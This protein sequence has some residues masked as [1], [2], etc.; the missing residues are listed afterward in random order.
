MSRNVHIWLPT[1]L[2]RAWERAR[3]GQRTAVQHV[4]FCVADHFE[5]YWA[6]ADAATAERRVKRWCRRYPELAAA[7]VDSDGRRPQHT[8]FYPAEEY[9]AGILDRL[10][11]LRDDGFG[12]VEVHLHHDNDTAEKL[13]NTL[14]SFKQTL[15]ERHGLLRR[16]P[17]TGEIVYA[18]IHGNWALDNSRPD[19]RW[20]GVDNELEVL[21]NTGCRVDMT[22]PSAPSPTQTRKINSLYFARGRACE[23]KAHDGGRDVAVGGWGDPGELLLIQ[24][25]LMLN[26]QRRK[27]G[28]L[29]RIE[30]GELSADN[31]PTSDRVRIWG[32]SGVSVR[33]AEQHLF[34]KVHTHGLQEATTEMLLG[35]GF[36]TMWSAL[37]ERFRDL[38]GCRLHYVTAW[39]M[40]CR[41][42]QL[43]LQRQ[44]A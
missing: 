30:N 5:P 19:G 35:G 6:S 44:A 29:P 27:A 24:G 20:C 40:Y 28:V 43:A 13:A 7:H 12:D 15:H 1:Y 25:P 14:I 26:W 9:E 36:D 37:E 22:M 31:P 18:F 21:V 39:E 3:T 33:G 8:M 41:V 10:A 4:Y 17:A 42:R 2:Q 38:P 11:Q 23:R 16:D 32:E 34:I